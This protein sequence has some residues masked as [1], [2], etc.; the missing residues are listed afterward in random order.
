MYIAVLS[1]GPTQFTIY[2]WEDVPLFGDNSTTATFQVWVVNGTDNIFYVYNDV[3]GGTATIGAENHTGT[4]GD[5]YYH[6]GAGTLPGPGSSLKVNA[7]TGGTATFN[8]DATANCDSD[9]IVN[10]ASISSGDQSERAIATTEVN[11]C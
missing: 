5:T 11:G 1:A 3:S 4:V 7:L 8:F 10:E 2:E 9:V 6:N